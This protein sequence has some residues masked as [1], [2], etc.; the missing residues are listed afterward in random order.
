LGIV[1]NKMTE[2]YDATEIELKK[3]VN[4]KRKELE[5]KEA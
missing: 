2:Q 4:E 1:R 5:D 3:K